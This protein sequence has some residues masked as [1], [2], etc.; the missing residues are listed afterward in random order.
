MIDQE[1]SAPVTKDDHV[2]TPRCGSKEVSKSTQWNEQWERY[3]Q[4][5]VVQDGRWTMAWS[6][7]IDLLFN[8]LVGL[9]SPLSPTP[10]WSKH[11]I[12][13]HREVRCSCRFFMT[14]VADNLV[15]N[16]IKKAWDHE[17]SKYVHFLNPTSWLW[18]TSG[19]SCKGQLSLQ[20]RDLWSILVS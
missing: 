3:D 5:W 8:W 20:I 6:K 9:W 14:F 4:M 10:F 13:V 17:V 16:G 18:D 11:A 19:Q 1:N 2:I 15:F 12:R 7:M